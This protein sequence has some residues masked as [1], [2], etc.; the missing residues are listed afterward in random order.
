MLRKSVTGKAPNILSVSIP[1]QQSFAVIYKLQVIYA[2][3]EIPNGVLS[4]ELVQVSLRGDK[5]PG[6]YSICRMDFH[7]LT[8]HCMKNAFDWNSV[9]MTDY[10]TRNI[11]GMDGFCGT[12]WGLISFVAQHSY[13]QKT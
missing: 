9:V 1:D 3:L 7:G 13:T 4:C 11:L 10:E 2:Y 8:M 12:T 6:I 5:K